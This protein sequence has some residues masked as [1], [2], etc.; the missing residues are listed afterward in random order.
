M[1]QFFFEHPEIKSAIYTFLSAFI[2]ATI[3]LIGS[4]SAQGAESGAI[5]G[6]LLAGLRAGLKAAA[7][8]QIVPKDAPGVSL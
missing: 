3:P 8:P 5:V 1:K 6:I 7:E 2:L 4:F